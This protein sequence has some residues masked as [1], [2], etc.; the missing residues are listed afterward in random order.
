MAEQATKT[1]NGTGSEDYE[2][3]V[4]ECERVAMLCQ[5]TDGGGGIG[6]AGA[7]RSWTG[8]N[9]YKRRES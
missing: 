4:L 9:P 1:T 5:K 3:R 8:G 6:N 7:K 2:N